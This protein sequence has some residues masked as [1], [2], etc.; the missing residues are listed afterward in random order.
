MGLA[1]P[2]GYCQNEA[3][4]IW[5]KE[6][7]MSLPRVGAMN[8]PQQQHSDVVAYA[9]REVSDSI[10][11][12]FIRYAARPPLRKNLF[13]AGGGAGLIAFCLYIPFELNVRGGI[14]VANMTLALIRAPMTPT[15]IWIP[16]AVWAAA[17][18]FGLLWF[19][20]GVK[21]AR[22]ARD[23]MQAFWALILTGIFAALLWWGAYLPR[24][25]VLANYFLQGLYIAGIVGSFVRFWLSV[26]GLPGG[27]AG[28]GQ[29]ATGA[30]PRSRRVV[31]GRA[32][33]QT[34]R[35]E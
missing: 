16:I 1:S 19:V 30:R 31:Q 26:R 18:A 21:G 4:N 29:G 32:A 9:I 27:E 20:V 2:D 12:E 3:A 10:N 23:V 5:Q 34:C 25:W 8:M 33:S 28:S 24:D 17:L 22:G 15:E 35:L 13:R 7:V 14:S 6:G 11:R